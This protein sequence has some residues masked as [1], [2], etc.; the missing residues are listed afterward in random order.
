MLKPIPL[1][2]LID[3]VIHSPLVQGS[4]GDTFGPDA[5]IDNVLVQNKK[6]KKVENGSFITV[7]GALMFWDATHSTS[8]T[9]SIGDKISFTTKQ[10]VSVERYIVDIVEAQTH[11][12]LHHLEL[13]LV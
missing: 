3:T 4:R 9:F 8:A 12:G 7:S 1:E 5:T 13:M 11:E 2:V 10:G 6:V